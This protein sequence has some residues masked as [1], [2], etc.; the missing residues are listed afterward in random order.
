[1]C[2]LTMQEAMGKQVIEVGYLLMKEH[3]HNGYATEGATAC[4]D[5][6]FSSLGANEVFSIIRDTNI[7]SINV[8][9]RN[10]MEPANS[11]VK[12]YKGVDML[13]TVYS[14]KRQRRGINLTALKRASYRFFSGLCKG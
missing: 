3:W 5:Y 1:M 10:G 7:P 13:H 9:R 11:I 12:H 6:A 4:R 14:V 8:A 2:G